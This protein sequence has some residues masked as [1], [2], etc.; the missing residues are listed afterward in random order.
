MKA[1]IVRKSKMQFQATLP[2]GHT[3]T[4]DASPEVGGEDQGPRPMEIL[5]SAVGGCSGI[6]IVSILEKMRLKVDTFAMEV[7]GDRAEDHPRR[8]TQVHIH[9]RLTGDLPEDKVRRA[10]D[11]SRDIYCS[12]SQSLNAQVTTSF[13]INGKRFD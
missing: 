3:V 1:E 4:M 9:Y 12:V 10:I 7:S 13:E 6:D 2:S 8:F 5:L 11:L